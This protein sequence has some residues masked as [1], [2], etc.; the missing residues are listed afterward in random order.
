MSRPV[1]T[2]VV[3]FAAAGGIVA[4]SGADDVLAGH[5]KARMT[6]N[7]QGDDGALAAFVDD[8]EAGLRGGR[9]SQ[10]AALLLAAGARGESVRASW[11]CSGK[12]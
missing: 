12:R 9:S 7:A 11:A 3:A 2:F 6:T 8:L 5:G 10:C 1:L 4:C